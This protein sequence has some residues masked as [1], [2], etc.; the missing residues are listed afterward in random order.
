[1]SRRPA[2]SKKVA[3]A[4]PNPSEDGP[5]SGRAPSRW[6]IYR[7]APLL[8]LLAVAVVHAASHMDIGVDTWVSLAGGRHVIAHGVTLT[9][10]F[11]FNSRQPA[12]AGAGVL[13][14][15]AAWAHPS[16]WIN[17]NWLT[18]VFLAWLSATFGLDA[19]AAW[20][21]LNYLLVAGLLLLNSHLRRAEPV[22]A[23]LLI[24]GALLASRSFF[25]VRAQDVTNLIAVALMVLL[26]VAALRAPRAAWLIV[27]LFA[28]W[29]NAHGGVIWGLLALALFA[30]ASA[31]A[32]VIGGRMLI[33][34]P[35]AR[36]DLAI[37]SACSLAAVVVTSPYR[38][39]NLT[40]PLVIS[41]SADAR[42]WRNVLEWLPL[43]RGSA[44]EQATF[45]AG[46]LVAVLAAAVFLRGPV[47]SRR[48]RGGAGVTDGVDPARA[49]DLGA[50][51]ILLT[52]GTMA[53]SSRRFL[54][55]AAFVG[56]PL[57]AQWLTGASER[58]LGARQRRARR[59]ATTVTN[60]GARLAVPLTWVLATALAA[61]YL[62]PLARTFRGP[63]PFDE[64]RASVAD[65]V[66]LTVGEPW[67]A[68]RFLNLN[69]LQGRMWNFW[70]AGGFWSWCE[71][72]DP[73]TGRIPVQVA[74]DGRAQAA[75]DVAVLRWH[76]LVESAGPTGL[77][78][79][80]GGRPPGP[81]ERAAMSSWVAR[82]LAEDG[83]WIAH[84]AE[85]NVSTP[86]AQVLLGLPAW[87]VVFV[88]AGHLLL[89]DAATPQ[90]AALVARVDA[91]AAAFPDD[92]S[93][94]LTRASRALRS[95]SRDGP[96]RGLAMAR[97]AW[98]IRPTSRAVALA[99]QA[100]ADPVCAHDAE[101]FFQELLDDQIANAPRHA[102]RGGYYER[103]VGA[104]GAARFLEQ[105]AAARG[106]T[107]ARG[108][109]AALV[110]QLSQEANRVA[111]TSEW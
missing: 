90:G 56:A 6:S 21:T 34:P 57:V 106:D 97:Q 65:R 70:E 48:A 15:L 83:I 51:A 74:I 75:Y 47:P 69:H 102:H 76:N 105:A 24:S 39:A 2:G 80:Q 104:V 44:T 23:V 14:R 13:S 92:V 43:A 46:V 85:R 108:R 27:P 61:A 40:H 52:T 68:C 50:A 49:F 91:G 98:A 45:V 89:V 16:G 8:V 9:D 54:P 17:Q 79:E 64:R 63:W 18:H 72:A 4:A 26:T 41:V 53:V 42:E 100:G 37:A 84:I 95:G 78:A 10:P 3:V 22:L 32:P 107:A 29:G 55:M 96:P 103:V 25:E 67:D 88:D 111:A 73:A 62:V 58:L 35:A 28:V 71:E 5:A 7:L 31:F 86:L 109:A 30:A 1:M 82:R 38:L 93:S 110:S 60:A 33:V 36:R 12:E 59:P 101:A 19:L 77:R 11:S 20:K 99:T 66:L 94:L 87:Q 81:A